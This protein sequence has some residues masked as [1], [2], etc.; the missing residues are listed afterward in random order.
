MFHSS[1]SALAGGDA[2]ETRGIA[3]GGRVAAA[4]LVPSAA[5]W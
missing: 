2:E 3:V 1:L 4:V 5:S